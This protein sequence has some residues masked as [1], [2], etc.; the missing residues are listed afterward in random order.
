MTDLVTIV[1]QW[2]VKTVGSIGLPMDRQTT[3]YVMLG[4]AFY[5]I[6]AA[7]RLLTQKEK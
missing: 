5:A 1:W 3:A 7:Y 2:W 4:L 6:G